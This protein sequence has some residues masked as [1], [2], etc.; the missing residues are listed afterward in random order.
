MLLYERVM[1][2]G[3]GAFIHVEVMIL[4]LSASLM[5]SPSVLEFGCWQGLLQYP[6]PCQDFLFFLFHPPSSDFNS[7]MIMIM[8]A[9]PNGSLVGK[10][11]SG[12]IAYGLSYARSDHR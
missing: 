3:S 9:V 7:W 10:H 6:C 11:T 12:F 8:S 1:I 5:Y 4:K 2:W